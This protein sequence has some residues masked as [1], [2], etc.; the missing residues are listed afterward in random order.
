MSEQ[1]FGTL[2]FT[3]ASAS[4]RGNAGFAALAQAKAGL[5]MLAEIGP[6]GIHLLAD[7]PTASQHLDS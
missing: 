3:G 2:L 6:Q 7:A 4:L 5:R 1:G